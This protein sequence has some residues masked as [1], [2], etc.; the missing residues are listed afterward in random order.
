MRGLA[1]I[2]PSPSVCCFELPTVCQPPSPQPSGMGNVCL[3]CLMTW[4][5]RC[6]DAQPPTLHFNPSNLTNYAE[7]LAAG[8]LCAQNSSTNPFSLHSTQQLMT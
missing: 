7:K 5:C 6:S 1:C 8:D 3:L 4:W 2:M